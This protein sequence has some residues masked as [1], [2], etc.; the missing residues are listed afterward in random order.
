MFS[1]GFGSLLA[2]AGLLA[3]AGCGGTAALPHSNM[4]SG[5]HSGQSA[6]VVGFAD[7]AFQPDSAQVVGVRLTGESS[8]HSNNYGTVLGYFRGTKS[9]TSQ[10]VSLTA[11]TTVVFHNVDSSRPHTASFL[12]NATKNVA[13]FPALFNGGSVKSP[14]GSTLNSTK[15]STGPLN[16]GSVSAKYNSGSPGFYMFGCAFHYDS[17]GMRTVIIVK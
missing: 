5:G 10:V 17:N 1:K 13:H 15:F 12:G 16:P 4:M 6:A 8:F 3:M 9:L 2:A 7:D 11:A 14:A